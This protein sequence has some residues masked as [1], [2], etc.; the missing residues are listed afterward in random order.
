MSSVAD[1]RARFESVAATVYDPLQRYLR[2]RVPHDQA[3]EVFADTLLTIWRRLDR[4]P[5]DQP[6]PWC[7]AVARKTL[8]NHRRGRERQLRLV[9]K[10]ETLRPDTPLTDPAELIED[11]DLVAALEALPESDQELLRLWAWESLEPREIALVLGTT[12]NSVSL[13]LGR[14]KRKLADELERQNRRTSGQ[15]DHRDAEVRHDD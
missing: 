1:R 10:L 13:R 9:S 6:L 14:A 8:A 3:E 5:Q 4:V 15:I 12:S 7:Y 11:G 2:R